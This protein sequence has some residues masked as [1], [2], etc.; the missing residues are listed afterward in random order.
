[1]R[2]FNI[3]RTHYKSFLFVT[4]SR[5]RGIKVFRRLGAINNAHLLSVFESIERGLPPSP[6]SSLLPTSHF[7]FPPPATLRNVEPFP[8]LPPRA[9]LTYEAHYCLFMTSR[10]RGLRTRTGKGESNFMLMDSLGR[11]KK[12]S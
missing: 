7:V 12:K 9:K 3:L 6:V 8:T 5:L 10:C 1:M 4:H 11:G 2:L